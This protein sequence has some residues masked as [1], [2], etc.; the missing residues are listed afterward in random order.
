MC[1]RDRDTL[2]A[3][4]WVLFLLFYFET[5]RTKGEVLKNFRVVAGGFLLLGLIVLTKKTGIYLLALSLVQMC[6]R[7]SHC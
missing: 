1:I 3:A 7:D 4:V 6:I 5:V 2:F